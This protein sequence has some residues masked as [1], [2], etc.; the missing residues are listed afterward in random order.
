MASVYPDVYMKKL[1]L[2]AGLFVFGA[3]F[4]TNTSIATTTAGKP[5][6]E[7]WAAI[8][9]L[10]EQLATIVLM[11]G[12]QGPQ[13]LAGQ[14]GEDASSMSLYDANGQLLGRL[15]SINDIS[16]FETE[17][18]VEVVNRGFLKVRQDTLYDEN[19]IHFRIRPKI[20]E[21]QLGLLV[22]P[23]CFPYTP[24][25]RNNFNYSDLYD[26]NNA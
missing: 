24:N 25:L 6:T 9:D 10:Q 11:P 26:K 16:E 4:V 21:I 23:L 12:P 14:D 15:I 22:Q 17:Y 7:M 20:S 19:G 13:G 3:L 1:L 2:V 18:I 8:Q 5:F